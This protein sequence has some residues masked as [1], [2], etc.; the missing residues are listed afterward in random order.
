MIVLSVKVGVI[1]TS[2]AASPASVVVLIEAFAAIGSIWVT[3]VIGAGTA[4]AAA[5]SLGG[6]PTRHIGR[7]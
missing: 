6:P 3:A 7:P 5:P 2:A 1:V 4:V